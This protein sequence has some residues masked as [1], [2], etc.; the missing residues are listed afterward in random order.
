MC[1]QC[2]TTTRE[3]FPDLTNKERL[4]ILWEYTEFPMGDPDRIVEQ[5][6]EYAERNTDDTQE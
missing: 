1:Q 2:V 5:L 4:D 3:L 6:H